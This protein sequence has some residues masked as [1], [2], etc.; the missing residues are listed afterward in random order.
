MTE[1]TPSPEIPAILPDELYELAKDDRSRIINLIHDVLDVGTVDG[2]FTWYEKL[3]EIARN[4]R[5]DCKLC[6]EGSTDDRKVSSEF[7]SSELRRLL[8]AVSLVAPN[9]SDLQKDRLH[10][11]I[12]DPATE[13]EKQRY[14]CRDSSCNCHPINQRLFEEIIRNETSIDLDYLPGQTDT[15]LLE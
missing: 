4:G 6:L 9:L 8:T 3:E 1:S 7:V 10:A 5:R 15:G 11:A 13:A 12:E 14:V 2:L